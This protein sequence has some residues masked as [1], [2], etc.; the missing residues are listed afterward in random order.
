M[1]DASAPVAF[2]ATTDLAAARTFYADTLGLEFVAE[3]PAALVFRL[4]H[5]FLRVTAFADH[6]PPGH[7]VLGWIVD[8]ID[9]AVARLGDRGIACERFEGFPQNGAGIATF[10]NG[11]R[12]AWF[13]DP[14]GNVLSVTEPAGR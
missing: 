10:P 1:F 8:D 13:R 3:E 12:V 9:D 4:A 5:G 11:D 14:A 6:L 2:V 7:T